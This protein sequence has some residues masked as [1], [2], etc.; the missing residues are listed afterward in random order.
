[1][2]FNYSDGLLMYCNGKEWRSLRGESSASG[3]T[4]INPGKSCKDIKQKDPNLPSGVYWINPDSS[5]YQGAF[6]VRQ[7]SQ[8][9]TYIDQ[10]FFLKKGVL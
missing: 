2:A 4:K 9:K 3:N 7:H 5:L 8:K 1:M 10:L 6:Q